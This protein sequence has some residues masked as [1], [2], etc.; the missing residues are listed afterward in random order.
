MILSQNK[1]QPQ[2]EVDE[3]R[4]LWL[5]AYKRKHISLKEESRHKENIM[6]SAEVV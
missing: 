4:L 1:L 3:K 5:I 2:E 6:R